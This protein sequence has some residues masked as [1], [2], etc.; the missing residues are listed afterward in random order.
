MV[1]SE[2]VLA[3][4]EIAATEVMMDTARNAV[5]MRLPNFIVFTSHFVMGCL[6]RLLI[7]SEAGVPEQLHRNIWKRK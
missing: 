5:I 2:L 3:D 4:T 1:M 7:L 6:T